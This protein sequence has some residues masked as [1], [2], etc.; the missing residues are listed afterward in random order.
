MREAVEARSSCREGWKGNH[1]AIRKII[2]KEHSE[3]SCESE[4]I[5]VQRNHSALFNFFA[6]SS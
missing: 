5:N 4:N 2:F 6:I 3:P 1:V